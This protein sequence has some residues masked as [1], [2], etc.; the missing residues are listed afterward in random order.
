[1]NRPN[2]STKARW[3]NIGINAGGCGKR[4]AVVSPN[5]IG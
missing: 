1:M 2:S 4:Y 3:K 5:T